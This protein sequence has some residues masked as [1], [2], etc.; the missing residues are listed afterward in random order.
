MLKY[1]ARRLKHCC[2][3]YRKQVGDQNLEFTVIGIFNDTNQHTIP[4]LSAT[5]EPVF[6]RVAFAP[7]IQLPSRVSRLRILCPA[8]YL[9]LEDTLAFTLC[10]SR[11]LINLVPDSINIWTIRAYEQ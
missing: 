6:E 1:H 9:L 10:T 7:H 2:R 11:T 4:T 3:S 8:P 5:L